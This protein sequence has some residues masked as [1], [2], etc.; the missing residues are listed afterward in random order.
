[1]VVLRIP[2]PMS[3]FWAAEAVLRIFLY[4]LH[5]I[6]AATRLLDDVF[7]LGFGFDFAT[8]RAEREVD[9]FRLCFA[10]LVG[11][12]AVMLFL[13]FGCD[14]HLQIA[15]AELGLYQRHH[16]VERENFF[17]RALLVQ[18]AFSAED[19]RFMYQAYSCMNCWDR[20]EMPSGPDAGI[21]ATIFFTSSAVIY[22]H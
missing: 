16:A 8:I 15:I 19:C 11:V 4:Q 1:M 5:K 10:V 12:F 6:D 14:F 3:P 20:F 7:R 2:R 22:G 13:L 18:T 21:P 17:V 9:Q